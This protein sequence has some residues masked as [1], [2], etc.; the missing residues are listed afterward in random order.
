MKKSK[1]A[2]PKKSAPKKKTAAGGFAV[3]SRVKVLRGDWGNSRGTVVE[4]LTV[5]GYVLVTLENAPR[6]GPVEFAPADLVAV[7]TGPVRRDDTG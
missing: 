2:A 3:G 5:D 4:S 6:G 7:D 1:K